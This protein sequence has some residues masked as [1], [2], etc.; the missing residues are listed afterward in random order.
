MTEERLKAK[1]TE[2]K[3][4]NKELAKKVRQ[5]QRYIDK[6]IGDK[7]EASGRHHE[8]RILYLRMYENSHEVI[9]Y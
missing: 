7:S 8:D 2:A 1:L 5:Q 3:R 6:L 9:F 4:L